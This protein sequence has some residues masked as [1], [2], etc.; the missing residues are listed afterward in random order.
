[1][2]VSRGTANFKL[3]LTSNALPLLVVELQVKADVPFSIVAN[4]DQSRDR[5]LKT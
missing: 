5:Q 1:M 2:F 3:E 4:V